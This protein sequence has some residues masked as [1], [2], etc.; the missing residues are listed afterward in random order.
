MF[1]WQIIQDEERRVHP[2]TAQGE[3]SIMVQCDMK[4]FGLRN[5]MWPVDHYSRIIDEH[6]EARGWKQPGFTGMEI[7]E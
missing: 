1:D 4:L 6:A 2:H 3:Q 5:G 7:V